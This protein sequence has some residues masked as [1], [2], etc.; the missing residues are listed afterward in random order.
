MSRRE[1][2]AEG[3]ARRKAIAVRRER[4]LRAVGSAGDEASPSSIVIP[5]KQRRAQARSAR[6]TAATQTVPTASNARL[7]TAILVGGAAVAVGLLGRQVVDIVQDQKRPAMLQNDIYS[8][9]GSIALLAIVGLFA[10]RRRQ[11][12]R[13]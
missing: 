6:A 2:R 1:T 13:Q 3:A 9:L 10:Y 5:A 7:W 8:A 4:A 12:S 11:L